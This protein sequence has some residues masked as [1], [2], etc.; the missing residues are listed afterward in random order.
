MNRARV[1]QILIARNA[2][3]EIIACKGRSGHPVVVGLDERGWIIPVDICFE[4]GGIGGE[5]NFDPPRGARGEIHG[6]HKTAHTPIVIFH[7]PVVNRRC[8][9]G[10][11]PDYAEVELDSARGPGPTQGNIPELHDLVSIDELVPGLLFDSP[12]H[13]SSGLREDIH[14]EVLI[15]QFD[16][17]PIH[18]LRVVAVALERVVGIQAGVP[19]Q[20]GYVIGFAEWIG[21]KRSKR[22]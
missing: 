18:G 3:R 7:Q 19:G 22:F 20:D 11:V 14:L 8:G 16:D 4:V 2:H 15:L 12:P 13:F 5:A 1:L 6:A 21:L 17:F 9:G 10:S